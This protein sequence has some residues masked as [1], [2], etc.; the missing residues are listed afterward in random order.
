MKTLIYLLVCVVLFITP[1]TALTQT[2]GLHKS[3]N[4]VSEKTLNV[5]GTD[6]P[7]R[8]SEWFKSIVNNLESKGQVSYSTDMND[9]AGWTSE[10]ENNFDRFGYSVAPAGDVNN[11]GYADVVIGAY[12]FS[13]NRGKAYL[14]LGSS[15]GLQTSFSWSSI[16]EGSANYYAANVSGAGDINNDGY[17]DVLIG[18]TGYDNF[19]GKM[20]CFLGSSAGLNTTPSWTK[21]GESSGAALGII[22]GAGDVNNDG[23]DDIIA[24]AIGYQSYK[25]K[26]YLYFG[27]ASGLSNSFVWS[28]SG[29]NTNDYFGFCVSSAGDLNGDSYDDVLISTDGYN[30]NTSKAYIFYGN[31]TGL[32]TSINWQ[33]TDGS[34]NSYYGYS[35]ASAGDVNNDG[36]NDVIV[37]ALGYLGSTGRAYAYYGGPAGVS[38]TPNWS[39]TGEAPGSEFGY[40]VSTAG[41]INND[42]FA[43][44]IIGA[45]GFSGE[46]GRVYIYLGSSAGLETTVHYQITGET[47]SRFGKSV[48]CGGDLNNDGTDDIL[49]GAYKFSDLRGKV[50][51]YYSNT[52][53]I[54][55]GWESNG[56]SEDNHFGYSVSSAGDVNNDGFV[57]VLVGAYGYQGNRGAAYLYYGDSCGIS[58]TP[59]WIVTG[60]GSQNYFAANLS[61][62]GDVNNDG[63]DDVII[64]ATGYQNFRGK[65]YVYYGSSSGLPSTP[66]WFKTGE[67]T[68]SRLGIVSTAG[69]INNDGYS[70]IVAAAI[71]H[72][73]FTGKTYVYTGSASGLNSTAIWSYNGESSGNYFGFCVSGA[74]DVNGDNFDDVLI[75]TDGYNGNLSKAYLFLANSSGINNSPSWTRSESGYYGYSSASAGDVNND[76]YSDILVG[77]L[78]FNGSTGK[79]Y[80]YYGSSSG[81]SMTASWTATGEY[82]GSEF[83]YSVSSA[84]DVNNDG[85]DDIIVGADGFEDETGKIYVYKGGVSGLSLIPSWTRTGEWDSRF[86][87]SVAS[88]GDIDNDGQTEVLAGAHQFDFSTGKA[89]LFNVDFSVGISGNGIEEP[90]SFTLKQNYPNPFNPS[91]TISFVLAASVN[92]KLTIYSSAGKEV[93]TIVNKVL[94]AGSHSYNFDGGSLSSG[95]Y[96]YK[97]EA[98]SFMMTRKMMLVK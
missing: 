77:A 98:G 11:D 65:I 25:G 15:T 74:G 89:Y 68:T 28:Y 48:A 4:P 91:T 44:V 76:G 53:G 35:S 6:S 81:V 40:C 59:N 58:L 73:N 70:D 5:S 92:A 46:V 85:Y 75:S 84:G 16:G 27:T 30:G 55:N 23:I 49:I 10:G 87:Q 34:S 86:G 78:G 72:N 66:S 69:D 45:D 18:A 32:S 14:Y 52:C 94:E 90:S 38:S 19:R 3:F 80:A 88:A 36:Y 9:N 24:G 31:S 51:A 8:N 17:D 71:G 1:I 29:E 20:Y 56:Q 7:I 97:L 57:D 43:D 2:P 39:V 95:I 61:C 21:T 22:S 37:G 79:A 26:C 42:G 62:A 93:A 54:T 41:D 12:G 63:Y 67:T 82:L 64:G 96:F 47:Y 83:G 13:G 50:Y 60:E 33:A